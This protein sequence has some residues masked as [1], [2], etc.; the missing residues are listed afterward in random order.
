MKRWKRIF[1]FILLGIL[2]LALVVPFLVPVPPIENARTIEELADLD[3]RF[4]EINGL[5]VHY[6]QA[7]QGEPWVILL[8]GFLASVFSW[9]EVLEP[10]AQYG[11][12]IAF[13]RPAFG[14]TERPLVWEQVNPYTPE[15]QTDLV[16]G[17]MDALGA[18]QA[19]LVGNSAGGA[20]AMYTALRYP[21]RVQALVLVD[22]AIYS[23]GGAP[24]WIKPLL[25]LPQLRRLGPLFVRNFFNRQATSGEAN[26]LL[27]AAWHDPKLITPEIIAGYS[28]PFQ[29]KDWDRALWEFT[30]A[31][32]HLKLSQRLD[33][34]SLPVLVIT[35]DDDRIVPA[36]ESLR[37]AEEIAGAQLVVIPNCGHVPQEECPQPF[38]E[39]MRRFLLGLSA[40]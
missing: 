19:I 2:I 39:A 31:S 12:V 33:E 6:K 17:L 34:L 23:G 7:G 30:L 15:A 21:A 11:T 32:R 9:R 29:V 26:Q 27:A 18:D 14:L 16:I 22:A 4:I 8:H 25:G 13:D 5:R 3:S 40:P 28:L 20:I 35:G 36:E 24:A 10:L 37:L 38:L 1:Y